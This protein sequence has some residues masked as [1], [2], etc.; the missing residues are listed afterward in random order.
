MTTLPL[1]VSQP[2]EMTAEKSIH[3]RLTDK[4]DVVDKPSTSSQ[5][6]L[7][8][9]IIISLSVCTFYILISSSMVFTNK[10]LS[11]TY[12]FKST[13]VLLLCQMLFTLILLRSLRSL[14]LI[15]ILPFDYTR[16]K[17]VA[18]VS[19]FYSLN[20]AVALVALQQLSVPSYTLIK[21][22]APLF[23]LC[24]E[25]LLLKKLTTRPI[26]ISLLV[27]STGTVIAAKSD[28]SSSSFAWFLGFASCFFQALY[29]TFVKRSGVTTGMDSFGILYYHSI[30]SIPC[31]TL[32]A[33]AMGEF[34]TALAFDR[35]KSPSFLVVFIISLFMGLVLNYALFLCTELTSPTSTVVSGQVKAM[36]QTLVGMF[37]FGGVDM[38][39][40]YS[41][42]TLLNIAG[43]FMYAY[44]KLKGLRERG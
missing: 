29:L 26:V 42:G 28:S 43:G 36:G 25:V 39:F 24:L 32:L 30:L 22:L 2:S 12:N 34:G 4:E 21:R 15:D 10:A 11:Y 20:A 8:R 33:L 44:A 18:P 17:Q 1:P 27:M 13:N 7:R 35:W 5:H 3:I 37:T 19:I 9:T 16:A 40:R 31:L 38:N 14:K 6:P 41:L 23:T